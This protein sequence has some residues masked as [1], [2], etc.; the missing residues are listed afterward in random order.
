MKANF[1]GVANWVDNNINWGS[2]TSIE[3]SKGKTTATTTSSTNLGESMSYIMYNNT[4]SGNPA[5][6]FKTETKTEV[7]A[8]EKIEI[9]TPASTV[10]VSATSNQ[11]GKTTVQVSGTLTRSNGPSVGGSVSHSSDG[12]VKVDA[13]VSATAG[14]VS[15]KV[16]ASGTVSNTSQNLEFSAGTTIKKR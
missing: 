6:L 2:K 16:S 5:S 13:N 15:S 12:T 1:Q 10:S 7:S 9:K 11:D 14:P 3:T 8:W 4:N